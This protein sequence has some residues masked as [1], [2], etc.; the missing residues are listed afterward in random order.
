MLIN[1]IGR[2]LSGSRL[3]ARSLESHH[4]HS[5][6]DVVLAALLESHKRQNR[7]KRS[8]GVSAQFI[9]SLL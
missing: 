2:D 5:D 9:F 8:I 6:V 4:V 3:V 7:G 1:Y